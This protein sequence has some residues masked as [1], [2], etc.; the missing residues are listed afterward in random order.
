MQ[1]GRTEAGIGMGYFSRF[2]T[3]PWSFAFYADGCVYGDDLARGCC[4]GVDYHYF[5]LC[6]T[7]SAGPGHRNHLS[8]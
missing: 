5:P 4:F 8:Y 6:V 3:V 7:D 2:V 1:K